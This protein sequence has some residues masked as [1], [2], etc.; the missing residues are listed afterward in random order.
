MTATSTHCNLRSNHRPNHRA[1]TATSVVSRILAAVGKLRGELMKPRV[2]HNILGK[3]GTS[4]AN[5]S[6]AVISGELNP[7]GRL[8]PSQRAS[9]HNPHNLRGLRWTP[10]QAQQASAEPP[11]RVQEPLRRAEPAWLPRPTRTSAASHD[12]RWELNLRDERQ[13]RGMCIPSSFKHNLRRHVLHQAKYAY[14]RQILNQ[15]SSEG[16]YWI[17]KSKILNFDLTSNICFIL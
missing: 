13:P 9:E 12:L 16:Y 3:L 2:E 7:R 15:P 4:S 10:W 17:A 11:R 5:W 8:Q 1:A 6:F 14:M